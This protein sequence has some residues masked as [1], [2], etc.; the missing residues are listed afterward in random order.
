ML[1]ASIRL[2]GNKRGAF[3]NKNL[4]NALMEALQKNIKHHTNIKETFVH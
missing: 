3:M 1:L 2:K 4:P